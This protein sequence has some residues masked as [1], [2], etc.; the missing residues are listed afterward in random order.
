M[1]APIDLA[2]LQRMLD[3]T[4]I[5]ELAGHYMR[6]LDRR[7]P[8]LLASVFHDDATTHFGQFRGGLAG[9][10]EMAMNALSTHEANQHLI[11]QVNL[12]FADEPAGDGIRRA[13]GE[14]YFQA[15]HRLVADGIRTDLSV[16]G[17]YL[18]RYEFIG[19]RWG[20]SHRTEVVD[21][22]RTEPTSDDYLPRRPLLVTGRADHSDLSYHIH[23]A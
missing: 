7:D 18:D 12:W 10:V 14:V 11:G 8:V 23:D 5:E 22:A 15:F 20:I 9:F 17:R 6:G 21:W 2:A 19:G 13:T 1:S 3:R 4:A 16:C